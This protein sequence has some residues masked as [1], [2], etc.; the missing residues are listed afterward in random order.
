MDEQKRLT[1]NGEEMGNLSD[2]SRL[3]TFLKDIFRQREE[4][5][6]YREN[7][8]EIEKTVFIKMP[9]A[10]SAGD[11]IKIGKALEEA[12]ASPIGF[13]A[14][15]NEPETGDLIHIPPIL[16]PAKPPR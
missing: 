1:L 13:Q 12:G 8:A 6:V 16:P 3:I 7:S 4:N 15:E 5:G 10:A 11:L 9:L 2:T 14:V